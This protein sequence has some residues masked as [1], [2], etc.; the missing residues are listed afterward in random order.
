MKN[1]I[2]SWSHQELNNSDTTDVANIADRVKRGVDL[3]NRPYVSFQK[4]PIRDNKYLPVDYDKY[5][6]KYYTVDDA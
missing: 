6:T 4:I 2:E 3:Y 5:L 1:K